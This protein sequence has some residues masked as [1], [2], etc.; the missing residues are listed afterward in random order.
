MIE[1][2]V[3]NLETNSKFIKVF[4]N[5]YLFKNFLRKCRFSKK[6]EVLS[7]FKW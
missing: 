2:E 7:W 1:A 5:E 4:D 6:V 3:L